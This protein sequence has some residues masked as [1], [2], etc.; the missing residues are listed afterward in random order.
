MGTPKAKPFRHHRFLSPCSCLN[1]FTPIHGTADNVPARS[2]SCERAIWTKGRRSVAANRL[3][4]EVTTYGFTRFAFPSAGLHRSPPSFAVTSPLGRSHL[5]PFGPSYSAS[6]L[7][8]SETSSWEWPL[9]QEP[10]RAHPPSHREQR[11]AHNPCCESLC[12]ASLFAPFLLGW[13][14]QITLEPCAVRLAWS[15]DVR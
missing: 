8:S 3:L 1:L 13:L 11:Q 6:S 7:T 12:Y 10:E 5:L 9:W 14:F 2:P 4:S 15:Q